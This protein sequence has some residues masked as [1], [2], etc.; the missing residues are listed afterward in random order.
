MLKIAVLGSTGSIGK[1][2]LDI[3]RNNQNHFKISALTANSNIQLLCEQAKEFKPET[4][5]IADISKYRQLKRTIDSDIRVLSGVEGIIEAATQDSTD[6]VLS[7]IVGI[8]GLEPT[9]NAIKKGKRIALANKETLVTAGSIIMTEAAKHNVQIIPVD[10]EHSAVFQCIQNDGN[11]IDKIILTAS[12]GPFRTKTYDEITKA[13]VADALNHP[14]WCMG[15]KITIDSATLMNKG[16]EVIEAKWL[17]GVSSDKIEVCIHPQSIIHS[18]VEYVDGSIIAQLGIPDMRLPIQYAL[19]Y[20]HRTKV[21]GTKL[22]L[23]EVKKLTF[24]KPDNKRFPCLKLAY[25]ALQQGESACVVLNGA[26]EIAVNSF[27]QRKIKFTDIYRLVYSVLEDHNSMVVS[28]I[29]DVFLIDDWSRNACK[30]LLK[31][32]GYN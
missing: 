24:E 6:L 16:L 18:M 2:T 31:K 22:K 4:I 23:S 21:T 29:N 10:S 25:D 15:K 30:E 8:A 14:N 11:N 12:G 28:S 13:T 32:G 1:Q 20:P 19:T 9:Y 5:A 3:V 27:L 26:N 7:A 17:F